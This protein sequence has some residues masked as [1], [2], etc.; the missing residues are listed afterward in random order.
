MLILPA[1]S[2]V[3][4]SALRLFI[5]CVWVINGI[6]AIGQVT[7][8]PDSAALE[9]LRTW[10][11]SL[12]SGPLGSNGIVALSVRRVNDGRIIFGQNDGISLSTAST[13][14]LVSTATALATL[15]STYSY[16]TTLEYDGVIRDSTLQG[17]LYLRGTGDPSLGSGRFAGYPAWV[18]LLKD[19]SSR[20]RQ[21]GIRRI[22]GAVIGDASFYD[23]QPIPDSWPFSDLGNYYGAGLFGLNF[24]ENLYRI[25]FK[26][27]PALGS[28]APVLRT[29]PAMPFLTFT[30]RVT[31]GPANSGD[32][33]NIYGTPFQNT[34]TLDGTIPANSTEF[35]VKGAMPDPAYF[36]A[37]AI[38]E[39]L[40]RDSVRIAGPATSYRPGAPVPGTLSASLDVASTQNDMPGGSRP[41]VRTEI[42][43]YVSP[44]L[45][46]LV[47][48][49]NF[50]SINLYAEALMRSAARQIRQAPT[51]WPESISAVTG[52]WKGK[53]IDLAGFRPRD[54]SGL[55]TSGALTANNLTSIL[56]AMT[57]EG[58]YPAFYA[59]IPVVGQTGTVR[60]LAKGTKAA[61]NVRAK[62]GTIEGVRAYA[63]Y[64]TAADGTLMSFSFMINKYAEGKYAALT[65]QIE[66]LFVLLVGL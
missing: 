62:S 28:P 38:T 52:F 19:I 9:R 53:G 20:V 58:A 3:S 16:T 17:N 23:D 51:N 59:S 49:T 34:A 13:L 66:R 15:G 56:S 55:S 31:V 64:F 32:E 11:V 60:G 45:S 14:K 46:D 50:Q 12:Q 8:S 40:R 33:V 36:T 35:A 25:Y 47:R 5:A 29:D 6:P 48:E 26:S 57:R 27:G 30:N 10:A 1:L 7:L 54:G 2:S 61:G 43:R 65:P 63:G 24:N 22:D 37:Y 41:A 39:Q 21:A 4:R 44:P 42:A 18:A